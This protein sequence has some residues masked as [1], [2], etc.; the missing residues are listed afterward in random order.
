M[1]SYEVE[2]SRAMLLSVLRMR[3]S[4][5]EFNGWGVGNEPDLPPKTLLL[6]PAV[7][8]NTHI[9][10]HTKYTKTIIRNEVLGIA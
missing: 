5:I 9:N 4:I 2:S 6:A 3:S 8:I 1:G 10:T 7:H